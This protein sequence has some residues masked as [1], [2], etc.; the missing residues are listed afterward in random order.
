MAVVKLSKS[1]KQVQFI[2]DDGNMFVTSKAFLNSLLNGSSKYPIVSMMRFPM[3][4]QSWRF[5]KSKIYNPNGMYDEMIKDM[6]TGEDALSAKV[7]K[8]LEEKKVYN[9]DIDI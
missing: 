6:D 9:V 7:V 4:V 1:G 3:K 5:T 2:D 8:Q